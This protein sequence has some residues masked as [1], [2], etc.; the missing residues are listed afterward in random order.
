[1]ALFSRLR[2]I[3]SKNQQ[4]HLPF[5]PNKK[6]TYSLAMLNITQFL[7]VINDNLFKLVMAYFLIDTLGKEFASPVL[8]A[9]GAIYVIPFLLFSSSAGIVADRFS[10]QKLLVIMKIVE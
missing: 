7:G 1:M 4:F 8:S 9:T 3:F 5:T 10:K 6:E 2:N